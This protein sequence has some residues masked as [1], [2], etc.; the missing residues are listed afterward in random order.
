MAR[1]LIAGF[2]DI[3]FRLGLQLAEAD[4]QVFGVRRHPP[5]ESGHK[6]LIGVSADV[7][8]PETLMA[9]PDDIEHIVYIL[10]PDSRD[11]AA[12]RRAFI[13]GLENLLTRYGSQSIAPQ[14]VFISSTSV[15][16]QR[17]GEW[18]DETSATNP[19]SA[20]A[21]VLVEAEQLVLGANTNNIV[22]RFSGIYGRS[23]ASLLRRARSGAPAPR[24]PPRY[25]NRIHR[26]DCVGVLYFL[27][28]KK[29]QGGA[30]E[31]IYLASDDD[32]APASEVADW[33]AKNL[34]LAPP[35]PKSEAYDQNKRCS[36]QRIKALGYQFLYPGY[37]EGYSAL[38]DDGNADDY[39]KGD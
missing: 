31:S 9:L 15:Y 19:S 7:S 4:H 11:V 26:D 24:D 18:V 30:M 21:Q 8:D 14:C 23:R 1:I 10:S 20:T 33:L 3:G 36:N 2:G 37:R 6:N 28:K 29:L 13:T 38:F 27:L 39:V 35:A 32:P 12:Y 5:A 25:T 17:H 34:D 16:G 22:L